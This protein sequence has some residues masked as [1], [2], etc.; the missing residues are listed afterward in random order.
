MR[1]FMMEN[2]IISSFG[3]V[4][5][6]IGA[7]ALNMWLVNTFNLSPISFELV[8]FGVIALFI[9]GQLAVLYP[10]RKAAMIAPATATRTI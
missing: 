8:I 5:G 6:C 4:I 7:V 9:V 1:Y 2:L 3:N 10:A